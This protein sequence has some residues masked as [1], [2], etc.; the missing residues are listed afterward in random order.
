M[1]RESKR[2]HPFRLP[3]WC[4][5]S[6]SFIHVIQL[7]DTLKRRQIL[8]HALTVMTEIREEIGQNRFHSSAWLP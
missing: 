4:L 6:I 3:L 7:C 5:A 1:V 2:W 8:A